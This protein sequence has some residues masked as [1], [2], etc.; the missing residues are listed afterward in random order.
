MPSRWHAIAIW[1]VCALA[2]TSAPKS[3]WR[4]SG[5]DPDSQAMRDE[6]A[7]DVADCTTRA[8][9]PSQGAQTTMSYSRAQVADCM[10]ARGWRQVAVDD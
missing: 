10:R 8:G 3:E 7:R 9:A 6:R 2:C 1:L 5:V 4:K